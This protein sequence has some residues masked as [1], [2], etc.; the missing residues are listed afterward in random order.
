MSGLVYGF[1]TRM[2][3]REASA[4]GETAPGFELPGRKCPKLSG[5]DEEA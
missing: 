3:N 5:Q 4:Q 2:S 1:A